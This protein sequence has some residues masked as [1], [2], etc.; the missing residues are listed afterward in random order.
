MEKELFIK[1]VD[2]YK[3]VLSVTSLCHYFGVARSTDYRWTKKEG[4]KDIRI[5]MIQRL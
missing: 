5:K 4:I 3:G 2:S 1:S